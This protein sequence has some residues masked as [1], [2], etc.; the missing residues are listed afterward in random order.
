ML[1]THL[2]SSWNL[3]LRDPFA[4]IHPQACS[5]SSVAKKHG[6]KVHGQDMAG[7][8]DCFCVMQ[9][10]CFISL[11]LSYLILQSY[12]KPVKKIKDSQR[13]GSGL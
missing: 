4:L 8:E 12:T 10:S 1:S 3:S 2:S 13:P 6:L 5:L 7:L 11:G 9:P